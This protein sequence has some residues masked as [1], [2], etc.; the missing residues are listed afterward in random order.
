MKEEILKALILTGSYRHEFEGNGVLTIKYSKIS[1]L[2][3]T[4]DKRTVKC[5]TVGYS[6][7]P[8]VDGGVVVGT[9]PAYASISQRF[10]PW[11]LSDAID[12]F[13][14]RIKDPFDQVV[15]KLT[16]SLVEIHSLNEDVPK[17]ICQDGT[18]V[19]DITEGVIKRSLVTH[20]G[21]AYMFN[22]NTSLQLI[23]CKIPDDE[24]KIIERLGVI[25]SDYNS[26]GSNSELYPLEDLDKVITIFVNR[27]QSVDPSISIVKGL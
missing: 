3:E 1:T 11:E 24:F 5:L 13:I 26:K 16:R 17:V 22:N 9:I 10:A 4:E 20:D 8:N 15:C 18:K 2:L 7:T 6:R 12:S 19:D 23:R 21:V 27:L 25:Y 14:E